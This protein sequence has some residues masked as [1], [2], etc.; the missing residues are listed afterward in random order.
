MY[1]HRY[2]QGATNNVSTSYHAQRRF[3]NISTVL[4][5][6]PPPPHVLQ[7]QLAHKLLYDYR[8]L[9][10]SEYLHVRSYGLSDAKD[11]NGSSVSEEDLLAV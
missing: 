9:L 3:Q 1:L 11:K 2:Y 7:L 6:G 8:Y 4:R 10:T 5:K